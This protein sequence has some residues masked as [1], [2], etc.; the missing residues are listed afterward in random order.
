MTEPVTRTRV[1]GGREAEEKPE[2]VGFS[3][4]QCKQPQELPGDGSPCAGLG[5]ISQLFL[6]GHHYPDTKGR[7]RL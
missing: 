4:E 2:H 3:G 7:Q 1:Q 5:L 6:R